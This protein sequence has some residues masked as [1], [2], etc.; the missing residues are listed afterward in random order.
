MINIEVGTIVKMEEGKGRKRKFE[1]IELYKKKRI[2]NVS[3]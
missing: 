3:M 2:H 1:V